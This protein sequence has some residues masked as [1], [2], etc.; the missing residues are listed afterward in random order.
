MYNPGPQYCPYCGAELELTDKHKSYSDLFHPQSITTYIYNCPNSE[1]FSTKEEALEYEPEEK[2][3]ISDITNIKNIDWTEIVCESAY[4][5][6]S[7]SFYIDDMFNQ[8][9]TGYPF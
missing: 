5:Y 4:H 9:Q 8:L 6:V 1:G 3:V 2:Q 7:G